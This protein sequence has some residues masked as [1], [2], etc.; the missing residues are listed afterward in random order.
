MDEHYHNTL[1]L[2]AANGIRSGM[3]RLAANQIRDELQPSK[4]TNK[5][6]KSLE[7]YLWKHTINPE[8]RD[9]NAC[10]PSGSNWFRRDDIVISVGINYIIIQFLA[11]QCWPFYFQ[12]K[13]WTRARFSESVRWNKLFIRRG[14]CFGPHDGIRLWQHWKLT[15]QCREWKLLFPTIS[16][17]NPKKI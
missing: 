7:R 12:G 4:A 16:D 11:L 10:P 6:R 13:L 3:F 14:S 5:N 17:P 8:I 1:Q 2:P 9:K 15:H